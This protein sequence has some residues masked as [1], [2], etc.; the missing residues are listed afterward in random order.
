MADFIIELPPQGPR[1]P[2]GT[3]G[4]DGAPGDVG[5]RGATLALGWDYQ[6]YSGAGPG[7]GR[8]MFETFPGPITS[9][10]LD[11]RDHNGVSVQPWIEA[12]GTSTNSS[13]KGYLDIVEVG[14]ETHW[15][16]FT[17]TG[18]AVTYL[19]GKYRVPVNLV[20]SSGFSF[21][22][23]GH[24]AV[25]FSRS[26]NK[27]LDGA[28]GNM[29][30]ANNLSEIVDPLSAFNRIKQGATTTYAGV[31]LFLP[32]YLTGL[33]LS[34]AAI[35]M[36]HD[37]SIAPGMATETTN[38][39]QMWLATALVKQIDFGW[40][41]G[42]NAGGLDSGTVAADTWYHVY[43]IR[44]VDTGAVDACFSANNTAPVFGAN[45]PTSYT[46][47]RRI[48]AVKTDTAKSL[49][50]FQQYGDRF[51]WDS[52][53]QDFSGVLSSG[54]LNLAGIPKLAVP[55]IGI[56]GICVDCYDGETVIG[57]FTNPD[58]PATTAG[59]TTYQGNLAGGLIYSAVEAQIRVNAAAQLRYWLSIAGRDAQVYSK[60]W[61]DNRGK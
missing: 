59:I 28:G 51:V 30:G 60:G 45:I 4:A 13:N 2:T 25:M 12:L 20:T 5:P 52:Q 61:I 19:P 11:V 3:P 34:N 42:T 35:D 50:G 44:R 41:V 8:I 10:L 54:L 27:G 47:Y 23:G 49:Y 31:G 29:F 36:V 17:V 53:V 6:D 32:N 55:P 21:D 58:Q 37:I 26:G 7:I 9:V 56:F 48:G 39:A 15:Y 33:T 43:L 18:P 38:T 46:Q 1:G 57:L 16:L 14:V 24:V 22:D 40:A